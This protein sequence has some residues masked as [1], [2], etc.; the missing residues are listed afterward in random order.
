MTP[1]TQK[2][3]RLEARAPHG[4]RAVISTRCH[5]C[6]FDLIVPHSASSEGVELFTEGK[7]PGGWF[8]RVGALRKTHQKNLSAHPETRE[9]GKSDN[10]NC[11]CRASAPPI[12]KAPGEGPRAPPIHSTHPFESVVC[13][14]IHKRLS[15]KLWSCPWVAVVLMIF[16]ASPTSLPLSHS[17]PA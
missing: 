15:P 7:C 3:L 12:K 2:N 14:A 6:R 16:T 11:D 5:K 4:T 13:E 1:P 9:T 10:P 8:S 17:K